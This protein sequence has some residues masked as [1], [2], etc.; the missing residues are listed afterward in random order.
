[1]AT[2]ERFR[3]MTLNL[4]GDRHWD[5]RRDEVAA[6]IDHER[7]DVLALQEVV[8]G[9]PGDP[10]GWLTDRTGMVAA[11]A[12]GR[13]GP[14]T[15]F[16]NAVLS[17]HPVRASERLELTRAGQDIERRYAL[18]C[19]I[20]TP[21]GGWD[22][23][24]THLTHL[25]QHG[26]VREAQALQIA[27]W[28]ARRPPGDLP[29]VLMGDLNAVPDSAEVRFLTGRQSMEGESFHLFDAFAACGAVGATWDN[30]N[31]WAAPNMVPDQRIDYVLVGVRGP[32]G[33]GRLCAARLACDRPLLGG[34]FASDHYGVVVELGL[35]LP[36]A[37]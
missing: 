25:F 10:L 30:A 34:G 8:R 18:R 17:R 26:F 27:R 15:E 13:R 1:M 35:P 20:D 32:A 7:P 36:P 6:W 33:G 23:Y 22:V 4:W 9:G 31:P 3:V 37:D 21:A 2:G 12:G 11:F 19:T 14:G 28:M 29:P 5:D 24:S 16:G